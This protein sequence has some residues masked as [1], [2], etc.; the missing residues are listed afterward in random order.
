MDV[1]ANEKIKYYEYRY[2]SGDW[3]R[4]TSQ[5]VSFTKE[6]VYRIYAVDMADNVSDVIMFTVDRT[7]PKYT[8][9]GVINKGV[10]NTS[11]SLSIEE[12]ASAV[13]NSHYNIP[14]IYTF[15]GDGY[16]HV[17]IRDLAANT[18]VLQFVINTTTKVTVNNKIIS[19]ISQHNA[20]NKMSITGTGYPRNSGYMLVKPSLEGGF[21]YVS[22]KL[23]S[24]TEYQKLI[25]GGTV[26]FSVKETDDTYMFVGFIVAS[27]E[28]NKFGTQTV[29][30]DEDKNNTPL[31]IG[32]VIF[33][34]AL[35]G[36]FFAVFLKRRKRQEEEDE[37]TEETII[38]DY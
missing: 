27:E 15:T 22:G 21:D 4:T 19:I 14:D 29:D 31:Y 6:G 7:P 1:T 23:F 9:S 2:Q 26:E 3:V 18:V 17:T 10:T 25:S 37:E 35:V 13:V 11:V 24:E 33:V 5:V 36:F 12:E 34:V 16:Y 30:G 28:L 32:L 8:L 20:I 38:D